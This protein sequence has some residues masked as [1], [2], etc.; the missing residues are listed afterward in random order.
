ML[1]GT[2]EAIPRDLEEASA[3]DGNGKV[4]TLARVVLPLAAP[5][6]AVAAHVRLARVVE[7]PAL[8]HLPVPGRAT[9]PLITYY[10]SNRGNV[11]DVATFSVILTIPV[12]LLTLFL[13]RWIRSGY[14]SGAV[15][16]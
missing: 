12:V 15:K 8:R 9:L 11:T 3:V 4:G 16:G 1:V 6:I 5:G 2:F 7:R 10:Y 13:Q 14:L